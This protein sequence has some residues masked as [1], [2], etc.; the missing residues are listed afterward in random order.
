M[1]PKSRRRSTVK[2]LD[3][4]LKE[5]TRAE[6]VRGWEDPRPAEQAYSFRHALIQETAQATLLR[7]QSRRLHRLVAH[8]LENVNAARLDEYA[9]Q[10]AEHYAEAEDENKT[11][12]YSTR[13]GD[14]AARLFA[15]DEALTQY[16][17][18]IEIAK[19]GHATGAQLIHL[20]KQRGR[21]LEVIGKYNEAVASY[22][23][24]HELALARRDRTLELAYLTLRAPLHSVPMPTFDAPLAKQL[25]LDALGTARE[26]GDEPAEARILW[27]LSLLSVH[28]MRPADGLTYGE[29]SLALTRK[30]HLR[31]QMAYTLHD[32]FIPYRATGQAARAREV[33]AQ[34]RA[35]F[36]ELDNKALLADNLGMSAQFA[37]YEGDLEHALEMGTEG[38]AVSRIIGNTFGIYFNESFIGAVYLERGEFSEALDALGEQIDLL[39][40]GE[41]S[42]NGA[43]LAVL[44]GWFFASIGAFP[45]SE[46]MER[47]ARDPRW[48]PIPPIFRTGLDAYRT[49]IRLARGDTAGAMRE[50][51]GSGP[52]L[53]LQGAL[54]PGAVQMPLAQAELALCQ[55]DFAR[56]LRV[57]QEQADWAT[58]NGYRLVLT[59]N[60]YLQARA[61]MGLREW[62]AASAT[63]RLALEN[64]EAMGARRMLWQVLAAMS[65][66]E[67]AHG[68]LAG[69]ESL[70]AQA[71]GVLEYIVAHMPEEFRSGFLNLPRVRE[72]REQRP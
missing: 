56:A 70:R 57:L 63:L 23:E 33:Q 17:R 4:A 3:A 61:R 46:R 2:R 64:A 31:E 10:L 7:N 18:A 54:Q 44:L 21:I 25:L 39:E 15:N 68:N 30:L 71:R 5:L 43:W 27:N 53:E 9:A 67:R 55:Q 59:E 40:R 41:F 62:E 6:L 35:L 37:M 16:A 26:L 51:A 36:R 29:A 42:L 13:A 48:E 1:K 58:E 22:Q 69:A 52:P 34:A 72:L 65:D 14:I 20:Y 28:T 47:L 50:L 38:L 19:R 60:L 11:L 24:L 32:L 12:E 8:A 45:Q 49:R 66:L